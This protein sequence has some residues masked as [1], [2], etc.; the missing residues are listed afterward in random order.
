MDI[1]DRL[2][3]TEIHE[4]ALVYAHTKLLDFIQSEQKPNPDNEL[5]LL[6]KSYKYALS[7]I[8]NEE[9]REII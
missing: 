8:P 4:L 2:E 7:Q 1:H 3:M 6:V 5:N 9:I